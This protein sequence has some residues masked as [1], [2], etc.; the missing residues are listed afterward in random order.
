MGLF[1]AACVVASITVGG[2]FVNERPE[3]AP[4]SLGVQDSEPPATDPTPVDAANLPKPVDLFERYIKVIGGREKMKEITS[5]RIDGRY[6]GRP[7]TFPA[8]LTIWQEMPNKFHL[9]IQQPAGETIEIG[10]D[11]EI[12]WERQPGIGLRLVE[13]QRLIELRDSSDFWGEV[14]YESKYLDMQTLG[15]FKFGEETAIGVHVK[16]VSGR[17]KVLVFS[18][19]S[20]LYLGTRT[21]T[22][23]PETGKPEQFETVLK[24]YQDVGGVLT[25][26]G[27]IQRFKDD[28][29]ATEFDYVK[30][31]VNL[32]EKHDFTVP[33]ELKAKI[34]RKTD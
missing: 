34:E 16:A 12:G 13:G 19:D 5:R 14:N 17:E 32:E 28:P 11:G 22:V 3:L 20:G 29:K 10:F 24:A 27:Q 21:L 8:R 2:N 4:T 1:V 6:I 30:V 25:T 23:H 7:F 15:Q 9:K 26:M 18:R 33:P 31:Q